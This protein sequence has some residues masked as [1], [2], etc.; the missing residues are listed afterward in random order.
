MAKSV[1]WSPILRTTT[2]TTSIV[3]EMVPLD[4]KEVLMNGTDRH[5]H[6]SD[7]KYGRV[8]KRYLFDDQPNTNVP[9]TPDIALAPPVSPIQPRERLRHNRCEVILSL[10]VITLR[11]SRDI[12]DHREK[13]LA[14]SRSCKRQSKDTSNALALRH[15]RPV[16]HVPPRSLCRHNYRYTHY[17]PIAQS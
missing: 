7:R 13:Y 9:S 12:R 8:P 17:Y 2:P 1:E 4:I 5:A 11:C 15:R 6:V 14:E 10:I 16:F 3:G